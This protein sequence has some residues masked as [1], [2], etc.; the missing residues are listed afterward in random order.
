M[1]DEKVKEEEEK[2]SAAAAAGGMM[3]SARLSCHYAAFF[4]RFS[5]LPSFFFFYQP[6]LHWLVTVTVALP[7]TRTHVCLSAYLCVYISLFSSL[8]LDGWRFA[9]YLGALRT[10]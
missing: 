6:L 1:K 3:T 10:I 2:K 5:L 9:V 8:A 4:P 7:C